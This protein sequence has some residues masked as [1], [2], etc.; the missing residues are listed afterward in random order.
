MGS[1]EF[2]LHMMLDEEE[3]TSADQVPEMWAH[4]MAALHNGP[5][6]RQGGGFWSPAD[7]RKLPWAPPPPPRPSPTAASL[8]AFVNKA[9]PKRRRKKK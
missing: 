3:A 4:L 9:A 8:R 2:A 1:H 5:L 7:F 6:R